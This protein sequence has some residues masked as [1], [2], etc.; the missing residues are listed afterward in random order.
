LERKIKLICESYFILSYLKEKLPGV[1]TFTTF[2]KNYI[3]LDEEIYEKKLMVV[4]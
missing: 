3:Y 1:I 2:E 4:Y